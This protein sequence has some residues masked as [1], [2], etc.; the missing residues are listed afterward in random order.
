MAI[1]TTTSGLAKPNVPRPARNKHLIP[2]V[3]TRSKRILS[4]A[5]E[6]MDVANSVVDRKAEYYRRK[7]SGKECTCRISSVERNKDEAKQEGTS[8]VDY[9]LY[10][11]TLENVDICP[12]CFNTGYVGGYDRVGVNTLTL[13]STERYR[14]DKVDLVKERPY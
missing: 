1:Y 4:A 11:D 3:T 2:E 6:E 5:A 9:L 7:K 10:N 13:D 12:I 8:L 14:L